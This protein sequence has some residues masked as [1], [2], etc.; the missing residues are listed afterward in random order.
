MAAEGIET[1][2]ETF[3]AGDIGAWWSLQIEILA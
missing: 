2:L 3:E 1:L